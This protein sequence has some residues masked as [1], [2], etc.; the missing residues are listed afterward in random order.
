MSAEEE[1][2]LCMPQGT[3]RI[4]RATTN[5]RVRAA[6]ATSCDAD[7]S[8]VARINLSCCSVAGVTSTVSLSII[9]STVL[10]A[11]I[12]FSAGVTTSFHN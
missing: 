5:E 11:D 12:R 2:S 10:K 9:F 4:A 7:R 1:P 6:L 3:L 8:C